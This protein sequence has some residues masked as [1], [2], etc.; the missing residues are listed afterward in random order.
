MTGG[1]AKPQPHQ[2]LWEARELAKAH[3]LYIV[4]VHDKTGDKLITAYVVYR[5]AVNGTPK[6]RLGKRRDPADLLRFVKD[7]A[8]VTA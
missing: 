4:E 7:C 6:Q 2:L 3:H 8:G 5:Q 1:A